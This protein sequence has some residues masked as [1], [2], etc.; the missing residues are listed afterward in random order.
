MSSPQRGFKPTLAQANGQ[1]NVTAD[2]EQMGVRG[3]GSAGDPPAVVTGAPAR[4]FSHHNM[5]RLSRLCVD[6]G[7]IGF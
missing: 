2:A 6:L 1:Y 5:T 4:H 3:N 7:W